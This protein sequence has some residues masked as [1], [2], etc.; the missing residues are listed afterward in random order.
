MS[1]LKLT[2]GAVDKYPYSLSQFRRDNPG[3]SFPKEMSD[4]LLAEWSVYKVTPVTRPAPTLTQDPSEQTPQLINGQWTQAW[5]MVDVSPEVAARRAQDAADQAELAAAKED[6][7]VRN[8]IAMTPAQ[9]EAYV[10]NNTANL[11]QVR[12]LLTKMALMMLALAKRE[13]R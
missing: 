9:V 11:A 5:A 12:A 6:T 7:F 2:D 1:Y 8:F 10:T 4:E 3:T 13:Y